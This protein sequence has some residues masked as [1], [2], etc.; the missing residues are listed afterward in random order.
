M[1]FGEELQ[2]IKIKDSEMDCFT[3]AYHVYRK[4]WMSKTGEKLSTERKPENPVNK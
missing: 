3:R 2:I 1:T 4:S